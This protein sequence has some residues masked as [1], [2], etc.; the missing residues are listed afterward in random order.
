MCEAFLASNEQNKAFLATNK[1]NTWA[2]PDT[3]YILPDKK[4]M[5][6]ERVIIIWM[7][8]WNERIRRNLTVLIHPGEELG[9]SHPNS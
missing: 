3:V 4:Y 2:S 9:E 8:A 1:Q 7:I 6:N 5:Y